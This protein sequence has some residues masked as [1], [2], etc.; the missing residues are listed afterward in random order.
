MDPLSFDIPFQGKQA[1]VVLA[2]SPWSEIAP[3]AITPETMEAERLP[4]YLESNVFR[5][6][7][8]IDG[9]GRTPAPRRAHFQQ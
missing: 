6:V 9:E 3:I 8:T 4:R 5:S 7:E 1:R 2:L